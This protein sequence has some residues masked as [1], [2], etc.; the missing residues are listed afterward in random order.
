MKKN[1]IRFNFIASLL[2]SLS[3]IV[4]L[5]V[6]VPLEGVLK[7][8]GRA[9]IKIVLLVFMIATLNNFLVS[10]YRWKLLLGKLHCDISFQQALLIKLGSNPMVSVLPF[11]SGE[12]FKLLY[13]KETEDLPY[14]KSIISIISEYL[15]NII[16]LLGFILLGVLI[17]LFIGNSFFISRNLNISCLCFANFSPLK[18]FRYSRIK[19]FLSEFKKVFKK[20]VFLFTI[21]YM[22]VELITI[23]LLSIALAIPIPFYKILIFMPV[24]I[25]LANIPITILGLGTREAAILFFFSGF[26]LKQQLFSLGILCSFI[27]YILPI[28]IGGS[29][30]GY[31]L[32]KVFQKKNEGFIS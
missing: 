31:F 21:L 20:D 4:F 16:V 5:F 32:T 14:S 18:Y 17:Q 28:I 22:I 25:L 8:I 13:L 9:D 26:G 24:T 2:I 23:H 1:K 11:R 27:E 6:K 15:L 30:T 19:I 12:F 3:I 29:V 10:A 7:S